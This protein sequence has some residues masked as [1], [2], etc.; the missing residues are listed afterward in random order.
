MN[1]KSDL[2]KLVTAALKTRH[3]TNDAQSL[4]DE[5]LRQAI[6]GSEKLDSDEQQ[7]I[8]GSPTTLKRLQ[9]LAQQSKI[10]RQI[11]E[12]YFIA[13]AADCGSE[14][15]SMDSNTGSSTLHVT[16]GKSGYIL[17]L[18]L[19]TSFLHKLQESEQQLGL[20]IGEVTM[21][22]KQPDAWGEV[23]WQWGESDSLQKILL[24]SDGKIDLKIS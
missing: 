17:V 10:R 18:K 5:I 24:S 21:P 19:A 9:A 11:S 13:R 20:K 14:S 23:T 12:H 3:V 1:T 16:T 2:L 4:P 22:Y 7:K 15:F 6:M 8:I